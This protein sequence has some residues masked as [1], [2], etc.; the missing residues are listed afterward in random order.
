MENNLPRYIA[1]EGCIGVGKTTLAERLAKFR[2][3]DLML[4]DF[5]KNPFLEEFYTDPASN[6]LENSLQFLLLHCHQ[7]H[8]MKKSNSPEVI[9]D[10]S[11]FKDDIFAEVNLTNH[12]EKR[13]FRDA[14]C[15]LHAKLPTPDLVVYIRAKDEL[16]VD[17]VRQRKRAIESNTEAHY[18]K[19]INASYE[20]HFSSFDGPLYVLEA[21]Q[22]DCLK[23]RDFAER[24]STTIDELLCVQV[25]H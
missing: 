15:I 25:R 9:T 3:A 2:S 16:I 19:S 13:L 8:R 18:F 22:Y 23:E 20:K 6:V 12:A 14:C 5:E 24:F 7:L 1:I 4:E 10:F 17:R 11:I 21:E